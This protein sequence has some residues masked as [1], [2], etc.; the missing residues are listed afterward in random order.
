MEQQPVTSSSQS[1]AASAPSPRQTQAA[2]EFAMQA[3]K[4]AANTR[5]HDVALLDVQGLSPV[6]DFFVL[7]TGTSARQMRSV[8]E[9]IEQLGQKQGFTAINRAG[10]ETDSWILVDFVDV[11]VHLFSAEARLYYDLDNLWGD[12]KRVD[13]PT[14]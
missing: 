4:L 3:G 10:Y 5:C 8:A 11:I 12:A 1:L 7:A 9:E 13:I 2:R 6:C 14:E